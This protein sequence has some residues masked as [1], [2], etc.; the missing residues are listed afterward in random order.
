MGGLSSDWLRTWAA[1]LVIGYSL[2]LHA[3]QFWQSRAKDLDYSA[4]APQPFF[5]FLGFMSLWMVLLLLR[6]PADQGAKV[7]FCI[8]ESILYVYLLCVCLYRLLCTQGK[9][10]CSRSLETTVWEGVC[11]ARE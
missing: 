6:L 11:Q 2:S 10:L 3:P 5:G 8:V 7:A 4:P 1:H 9:T